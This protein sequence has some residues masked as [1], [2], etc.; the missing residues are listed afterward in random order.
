MTAEQFEDAW[1]RGRRRFDRVGRIE[2]S[3]AY[4]EGWERRTAA[5]R[6]ERDR[7]LD[8]VMTGPAR[9]GDYLRQQRVDELDAALWQLALVRHHLQRINALA[10]ADAA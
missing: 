10:A 1:R 5:L 4:V 6:F 7:W 2:V 8:V 9:R 3:P